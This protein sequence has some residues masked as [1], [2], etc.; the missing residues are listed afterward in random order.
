MKHYIYLLTLFVS[1]GVFGGDFLPEEPQR[2]LTSQKIKSLNEKIANIQIQIDVLQLEVD[3][4]RRRRDFSEDPQIN[5]K[6]L[7]IQIV[8][9]LKEKIALE[10]KK[11]KFENRLKDPTRYF[12]EYAY[13]Q[14]YRQRPEA[15]ARQRKYYKRALA[16]PITDEPTPK[17]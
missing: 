15:K 2:Q 11:R 9:N 8:T 5:K 7:N 14:E 17:T 10:R 3:K 1:I 4:L 12:Q 6:K 16:L 13:R